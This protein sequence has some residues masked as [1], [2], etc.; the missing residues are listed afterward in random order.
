MAR[1][2]TKKRKTKETDVACSVDV[3]GTGT[4][5]VS[6]GIG[7][8]D[9]MLD[10]LGRHSLIDLTV[11]AKGDTEVDFHHTVEDVGITFGIALDKALGERK[12]I[13][14]FGFAAVPMDEALCEVA[15]DISGR[16]RA[17]MAGT[18]PV[19]AP[20]DPPLLEGF[21]S[22]VAANAKITIHAEAR[23][24]RDAHHVV[25]AIFKALA[26]ALRQAVEA[27]PR[28]DTVHSTKGVI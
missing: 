18:V 6:T 26:R 27:D 9:H 8:L 11:E 21:L 13:M 24:G 7:F 1:K 22:S 15:V 19:G 23:R 3:D 10:L 2:G 4:T 5:K 12:G 28:D 17:E 16:G 14:R 20:I 25:E